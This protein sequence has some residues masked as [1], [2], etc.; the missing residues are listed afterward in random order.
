MCVSGWGG[1]VSVGVM[2][3]GGGTGRDGITGLCSV[4]ILRTVLFSFVA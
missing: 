2:G 4:S 3:G 1:G